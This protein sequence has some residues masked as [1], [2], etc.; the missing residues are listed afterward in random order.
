MF[1]AWAGKSSS[2]NVKTE[3]TLIGDIEEQAK[4]S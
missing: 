3:A 4:L 1:K 2:G